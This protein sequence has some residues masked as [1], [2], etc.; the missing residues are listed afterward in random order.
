MQH[1][2]VLLPITASWLFSPKG[3]LGI[4]PIFLSEPTPVVLC[5]L[6]RA[7]T[8]HSFFCQSQPPIGH[9]TCGA[10]SNKTRAAR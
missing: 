5:S 2:L 8:P 1:T 10:G 6:R 4:P 3:W 7:P 9:G